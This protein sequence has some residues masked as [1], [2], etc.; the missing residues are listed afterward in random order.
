MRA[1]AIFEPFLVASE[2]KRQHQQRCQDDENAQIDQ[3]RFQTKRSMP[4]RSSARR[5]PSDSASAAS[6]QIG[7]GV[8]KM[9]SVRRQGF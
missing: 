7:A 1:V 5:N 8:T 9:P 3:R 4:I 6:R 2:T